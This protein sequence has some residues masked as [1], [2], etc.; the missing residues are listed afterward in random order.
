MAATK[1]KKPTVRTYKILSPIQADGTGSIRITCGKCVEE[2]AVTTFPAYD[3]TATGVSLTKNDGKTY[4]VA[5][6]T[7]RSTA[8]ECLG[9]LRHSHCKH[10]DCLS[11]MQ[12]KGKLPLPIT[13]T[14]E[15]GLDWLDAY[16][17]AA[18]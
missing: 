7:L 15:E 3:G 18:A 14:E 9:Y 13:A 12:A 16:E 11:A 8:C 6:G 5:L 10:I 2:Y 17:L 4:N 1:T